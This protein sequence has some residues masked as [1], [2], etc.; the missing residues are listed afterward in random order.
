MRTVAYYHILMI[1]N[2]QEIVEEQL[3][4]LK[5]SGLYDELTEIKVVCLGEG[6]FALL[7]ILEDYPKAKIVYY[8]LDADEYEFPTLDIL[9]KD[10]LDKEEFIGLYFHTK[11]V[12]YPNHSGGIYWRHYMNYYNIVRWL[13][14]VYGLDNHDLCGAKLIT[15][16]WGVHFSGN[17]FWFN[18]SYIATLPDVDTLDKTNRF[19]AEFWHGKSKPECYNMSDEFVDYNTKGEFVQPVNY[20]HTLAYNL[21]S[22]VEKATQQLY[23][24]NNDFCHIIVDLG[25]PLEE[26]DV[27]PK[28]IEKAKANNSRKLKTL[29]KKYGSRYLKIKNIGVSQNW[30]AVY[31]HLKMNDDDILIGVDPDERPQQNNWVEAMAAVLRSPEKIGM[32]TLT[33]P[34][35]KKIV[36]SK[37]TFTIS[38]VKAVVPISNTN[39]ALIGFTK[40]FLDEMGGVPHP[41]YAERYGWIEAEVYPNFEKYGYDLCFLPDYE[42]VHTDYELDNSVGSKILREW[43]NLVVFKLKKYG[44]ISLD[45]YLIRKRSGEKF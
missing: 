45:E 38:G 2:W 32:A 36:L 39:W 24:M 37:K 29:A 9:H 12:S 25:F 40:L 7:N 26:S 42:V 18:S 10:A 31:K 30:T 8:S 6:R 22:E 23:E 20:C 13:D 1:N 43:K 15:K 44:Q 41:P 4:L 14:C 27:I 16:G 5:S 11:G 35:Q 21:V 17:F 19:N 33:M 3:S 28:N 34:Q